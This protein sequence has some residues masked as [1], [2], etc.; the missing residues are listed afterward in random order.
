M[1]SRSSGEES[2]EKSARG[3]RKRF[4]RFG[5]R[6][7][8]KASEAKLS[9]ASSKHH[10]STLSASIRPSASLRSAL[11]RGLIIDWSATAA[12]REW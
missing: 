10:T 8:A 4:L 11:S 7:E 9:Q 2:I 5:R 6:G 3:G 1:A 12:G